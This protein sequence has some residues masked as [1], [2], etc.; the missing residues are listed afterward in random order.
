MTTEEA[1]ELA[2]EKVNELKESGIDTEIIPS[3]QQNDL[4]TIKK[5][6]KPE[7]ISP[8]KWINVSFHIEKEGDIDK[9][10]DAGTY[11]SMCGISF[12]TGGCC[13]CRDWELDWSFS[14]N[15]NEEKMK[16]NETRADV[17]DMIKDMCD[18]KK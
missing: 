12:D 15:K 5:Y 14:Y 3:C 6:S 8:D 7:N 10:F 18:C 13:G 2:I 16:W 4:N 1:Y 9:V 11:L 17:E